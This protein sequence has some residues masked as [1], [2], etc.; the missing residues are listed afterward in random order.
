MKTGKNIR[1]GGLDEIDDKAAD[2]IEMTKGH[3][4]IAFFGHMGVGKTTFIK[5]L[6]KQLGAVDEVTRPT[7]AIVNE[8]NTHKDHVIY[9]FD[10]Y[11]IKSVEEAFDFGFE[12]YLVSGGYCFIEWPEK[13]EQILPSSTVKVFMEEAGE[14]E[15]LISWGI[16]GSEEGDGIKEI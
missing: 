14:G 16:A 9:H 10:F 12:E 8:Y 4:I 13:V 3:K 7:F 2:F 6:C 1:I 11:R 15:R 5:A